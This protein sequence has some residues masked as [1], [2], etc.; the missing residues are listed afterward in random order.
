MSIYAPDSP[1]A[2]VKKSVV[3]FLILFPFVIA[4]LGCALALGIEPRMLLERTAERAFRVTGS[5]QFAGHQFYSKTIEGVEGVRHADGSRNRR[6]D[7]IRERNR[8]ASRKRLVFDAADGAMLSWDREDDSRLIDE[9]MRSDASTL[10]LKDPPPRWRMGLS[11]FCAGLGGLTLF[12]VI[13]NSFFPKRGTGL[14]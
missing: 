3:D 11:W 4:L 10:S 5:N 14:P 12:G 1:R 13:R 2:K 8:Q 7:S 6:E 9:F